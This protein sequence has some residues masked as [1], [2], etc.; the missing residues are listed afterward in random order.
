M[1]DAPERI[2]TNGNATMIIT[3]PAIPLHATDVEWVRAD[4]HRA[5]VEALENEVARLREALERSKRLREQYRKALEVE[6]DHSNPA[7]EALA[8]DPAAVAR[9]VKGGE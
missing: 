3:P 8:A 7:R 5:E 2:I 1:R 9:I 6:R 4:I